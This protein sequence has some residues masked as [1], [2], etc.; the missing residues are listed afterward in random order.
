MERFRVLGAIWRWREAC[1]SAEADPTEADEAPG[2]R[3]RCEANAAILASAGASAR[4]SA[5]IA[6]CCSCCGSQP[7]ASA[8]THDAGSDDAG[9]A[10][11]STS[12]AV[13]T[14]CMSVKN[15]SIITVTSLAADELRRMTEELTPLE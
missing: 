8:G 7:A 11:A 6:S 5:Q 14:V 1:A 9:A 12:Q 15:I 10:G 2:I 3:G 13:A 4:N